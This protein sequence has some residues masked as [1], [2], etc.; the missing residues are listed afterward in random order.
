MEPSADGLSAAETNL[1]KALVL[2]QRVLPWL[3]EPSR[4]ARAQADLSRAAALVESA[5]LA[6]EQQPSTRRAGAA[7]ASVDSE[8][9]AVIAAAIAAVLG[10]PHRLLS[11][12]PANAPASNLNVWAIEG[13]TQ[14]FQ[15]H[16]VR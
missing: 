10:S 2:I 16:R 4:A 5:R 9:A 7:L 3:D 15:S 12:S 11:V 8:T 6:H 1:G 13:R 14:I